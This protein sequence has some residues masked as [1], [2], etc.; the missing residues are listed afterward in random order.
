MFQYVYRTIN[1]LKLR[2]KLILS[3]IVVVFVPVMIVGVFLTSELRH[4]ALQN[5][6]EQTATNVD[7][8]KKRT[9]E[10]INVSTD[11]AYRLTFDTRLEGLANNQYETVYDVVKAYREYPDIKDYIRL[12]K[13][14]SNIRLYIKNT[15]L[16]NNWELI[17]PTDSIMQSN[18]YETALKSSGLIG[19]YYIEDER[20]HTN[21][22]SL[23]RKID[24]INRHT[25]AV[26]VINVNG[27]ML[28][29]ILGQESFDT[30][31]VDNDNRI[32]SA[33]RPGRAGKTLGDINFDPQVV[34]KQTGSF[35]A[36]VDGQSS[37]IQIEPL[38]PA[39]SLNGLRII[40]VFSIDSIVKD[41]NQI[42]RLALTVIAISLIVA[43][44]LI[45]GFATMLSK[46]MFRLSKH[47]SKVA[48]GNLDV[49]VEIDGKDEIGQLSRQFNSMVASINELLVEVQESHEQNAQ[50]Q[51][52]QNEI[53]FKMMASQINPHFLFNALES[54]R[55]KAH[56][57]GEK[58]ISNVVRLLGKMMRKNLEAGNRTVNLR[59]EIEV[60]R[61]YLDIQKFRYED[62]LRYEL[63]IDEAAEQVPILP[64]IIQ[65]LVENAVI[66]GLET[67]E[68]GGIVRV[69]AELEGGMLHVEVIDNGEGMSREKL[70]ALYQSFDD[71]DDGEGHRIGLR[72]VHMRLKL[73]YGSES[74]LVIW[75]EPGIGTRVQFTIPKGE[76]A[77]V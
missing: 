44:G 16:L 19:W 50:I 22:L 40:S 41:A 49:T 72:N 51:S 43:F 23:V 61:C 47:I 67:R 48:T 36:I 39:S 74:G 57:K 15:T 9:S 5:A 8:V 56:L 33:N 20:D 1:D 77:H 58:E 55:M 59:H 71:Q 4:M 38:I 65:P 18:W 54:I 35:Q 68:E 69:I 66:H 11:I 73:L 17:Q 28:N 37:Q 29:S 13:E 21:Y 52:K 2:T 42:I 7:R 3:C 31:I 62:R 27:R 14:I 60:V 25:S 32:I 24:F 76:H 45:Y 10:V 46:R 26:L 75:S 34:N 6:Q 53:K 64:L 70:Q 12:Y 30:M 63:R